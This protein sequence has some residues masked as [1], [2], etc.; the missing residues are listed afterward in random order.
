M[1][2]MNGMNEFVTNLMN[3]MTVEE[4]IGQMNLVVPANKPDEAPETEL[5][6]GTV[7]NMG[8]EEKIAAGEI[9][10]IL[11]VCGPSNVMRFQTM[12]VEQS[13]LGIPLLFGLDVIHGHKTSFPI[14]LAL[15][16]TWDMDLIRNSARIAAREAVADG[17]KWVFS[18]MVD[19]ARDPRW[20]R[21]AEG[22]G[23]DPYLG[24]RIAEAMIEGYQTDDMTGPDAVM[25]CAKHFAGYGF[26]E[27][28]RDY[29]TVD[30]SPLKLQE[31]VLPPFRAASKA[32]VG[33]MMN[34]FNDV[35]G[36]PATAHKE[37]MTDIARNGW[38]YNGFF[39]SDYTAT[40]EM[41]RHGV[42]D[43]Q[44]VSANALKAGLDMDMVG[45]GLHKTYKDSLAQGKITMADIDR[46]CR[47]VLEAKYKLGL[48][49]NPY[50]GMDPKNPELAQ[51]LP[52]SIQAAREAA[53]KSCVLLK[54][55]N[56]AL[57]LKKSGTIALVGP[58]ADDTL[59]MPGMWS[60]FAEASRTVGALDGMINAV[61][62][63]AKIIFAKGANI[64]DDLVEA[65]RVN[66]FHGD[67]EQK[68]VMIDARS[69]AEM[70]AEA[71]NAAEQ[72]DVIVAVVGE[73]S[74]HTGEASSR[75]NID[76]PESQRVLLTA[77]SDVAKRTG[78]PLVVVVM[79]GRPLTLGREHKQADAMLMAWHAGTEAG[80]GLADVLFGDYNPSGKL[81]ISFPYNVGQIPLYYG[82]KSTGRPLTGTEEF[83]K[84]QSC[85]MD[86]P[87][88]PLYPFG[89]GL[90][91]TKFDYSPV[92]VNKENL[93]GSDKLQ[94]SIT[95]KN[96]GDRAGEEIVQMYIT[97]PVC[98]RTR[99]V[100]ELKGFE[101]VMLQPG[102]EK[103]VTFN[104]TPEDLKFFVTA[105]KFAWEPGDF[106]IHIGRSSNDTN[107]ATIHW[108]KANGPKVV[109]AG[110]AL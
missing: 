101:K 24:S 62:D 55:D 17:I 25:A 1:S 50:Y 21:I 8:T 64:T 103:E 81:T 32:G 89:H 56:N 15:S 86:S 49:Q 70:L 22:S 110:P 90:S 33:S 4:K 59:N 39:V 23:E 84:F 65:A 2:D 97:D 34:A 80:N 40:D 63:K 74:Q 94:A 11:N 10:A 54:N 108:E 76:L 30:M 100:K 52:E 69:S 98:S 66:V 92:R 26:V 75:S 27:A 44:E 71:V 105:K 47:A 37:L 3:Q 102:E 14:P 95:L 68:P 16:S 60:G 104:I 78:K 6:T 35:N 85:Y 79:S 13:R 73:G 5:I 31:V 72:A 7:M 51:L 46:G 93:K 18:P 77:L 48:F 42:G 96:T 53:A 87:I 20:G 57:P 12:A 83:R 28:G 99:P 9:G 82:H 67:R 88:G 109:K 91:Y 36:I 38:G 106:I 29:N 107:T 45:E 41:I 43:L 61:G 58:L 19:I